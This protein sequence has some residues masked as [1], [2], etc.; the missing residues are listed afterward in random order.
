[1]NCKCLYCGHNFT[2][3]KSRIDNGG[4]KFCTRKCVDLYKIQQSLV[5]KVCLHCKK[6]FLS[7]KIINRIY[8]SAYC[9]TQAFRI[10]DPMICKNC[11]TKF[12]CKNGNRK[13]KFCTKICSQKYFKGQNSPHW[14]G[15]KR[16]SSY[17]GPGWKKIRKQIL[18]RDKYTCQ[19][20][21]AIPITNNRLI[22]HH[23]KPFRK[24]NGN[25][26]KANNNLNLIT[27]CRSCHPKVER[28]IIPCPQV[29]KNLS[30]LSLFY[31]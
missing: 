9:R 17:R 16:Y 13:Q 2:T 23:I 18:I 26:I 8:C 21:S 4:G 5:K 30:G 11:G 14:R 1:M 7:K 3:I 29:N 19:S 15:G 20:C 27:L 6:E 12:L 31:K 25:Y 10:K 22:I 28:G 24:F